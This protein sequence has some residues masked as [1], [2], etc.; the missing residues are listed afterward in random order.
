MAQSGSWQALREL[1]E[2]PNQAD[3]H[4]KNRRWP[5][6]CGGQNWFGFDFGNQ[7]QG[8]T[9]K[10]LW[11]SKPVL[12]SHFGV[13]EFTTHFGTYFSGDWDVH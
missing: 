1:L 5:G 4:A 11:L 13:G 12:E 2:E 6:G 8:T 9:H 7:E 10:W 3:S